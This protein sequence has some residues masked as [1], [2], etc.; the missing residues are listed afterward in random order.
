ML[1]IIFKGTYF[2]C[3]SDIASICVCDKERGCLEVSFLDVVFY[4]LYSC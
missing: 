1:V 4:P 3:G 2:L